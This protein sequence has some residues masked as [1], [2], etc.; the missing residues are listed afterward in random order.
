[1]NTVVTFEETEYYER[2]A[3]LCNR[4]RNVTVFFTYICAVAEQDA[5]LVVTECRLGIVRDILVTI[6]LFSTVGAIRLV[7]LV[8]LLIVLL[9]RQDVSVVGFWKVL[10]LQC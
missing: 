1:M 10:I 3:Q 5:V 7:L 4:V 2:N 6:V 8:C 9:L